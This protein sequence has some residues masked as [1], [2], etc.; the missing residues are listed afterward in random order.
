[1]YLGVLGLDGVLQPEWPVLALGWTHGGEMIDATLVV[2]GAVDLHRAIQ[3]AAVQ[4]AMSA[5]SRY[6]NAR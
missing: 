4:N 2:S 3:Q 6:H 5:T 1:M